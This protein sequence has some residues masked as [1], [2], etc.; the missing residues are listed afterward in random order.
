MNLPPPAVPLSGPLCEASSLFAAGERLLRAFL[1]AALYVIHV[2]CS[3]PLRNSIH[4]LAVC[5]MRC[6]AAAVWVLGY[7]RVHEKP[8]P[9]KAACE[10]GFSQMRTSWR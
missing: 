10:E 8:L 1:F 4:D 3:P 2:Y 9:D 5:I 6:A 7:G